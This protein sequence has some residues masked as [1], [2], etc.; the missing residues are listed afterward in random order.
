MAILGV[1]LSGTAAGTPVGAGAAS[2]KL[3]ALMGA[4]TSAVATAQP[5]SIRLRFTGCPFKGEWW[6]TVSVLNGED[7]ANVTPQRFLVNQ[8]DSSFLEN[9]GVPRLG[10]N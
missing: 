10:G 1:E 6:T 2:A 3:G 7:E 9:Q 4:S 8:F 5:A